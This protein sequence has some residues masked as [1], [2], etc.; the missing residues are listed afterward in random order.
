M[1]LRAQRPV[2][3]A[4]RL[5]VKMLRD[6]RPLLPQMADK[7][8]VRAF[9]TE[10]A[11]P[12]YVY[13][14]LDVSETVDGIDWTALPEEYV[15]KVNHGSGGLV[16]VSRDAPA[17]ARLPR[18]GTRLFWAKLSVRPAHADTERIADLCRHWLTLDYS[19]S[20]EHPY[21]QWCYAD[22]PRRV[23]VEPLLRSIR[24]T[25]PDEYRVFVIGGSVAFVQ[26]ECGFVGAPRTAVMSPQWEMLPFRLAD[27]GPEAPPPRPPRLAEMLDVAVRLALPV[28]DF[29]RVDF[30]DLGSK[31]VVGELTH[32][33]SGG[34]VDISSREWAVRFGRGWPM[35]Y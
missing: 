23:L 13:P 7:V 32:Y 9:I 4:D 24:G 10:H 14:M 25:P 19:W 6:R 28:Q 11:G 27:P 29:L 26:V 18:A 15:A 16:M 12:E 34:R 35:P 21:I 17:D 30:Y 5:A 20:R 31:L 1:W 2:T 3:F 8:Q 22:I 33:P